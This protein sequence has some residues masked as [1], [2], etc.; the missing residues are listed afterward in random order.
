MLTIVKQNQ[1]QQFPV[2]NFTARTVNLTMII[3]NKYK[4][5]SCFKLR[6]QSYSFEEPIYTL[7]SQKNGA[8]SKVS[9]NKFLVNYSNYTILLWTP[10][11]YICK[12]Q[13]VFQSCPTPR[14]HRFLSSHW[15]SCRFLSLMTSLI[16]SIQFFFG[17]PLA[18][19]CFWHPPFPPVIL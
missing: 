5:V 13:N 3:S 6:R 7:C 19:F 15:P 18:L 2:P 17:L 14:L 12:F 10:C 4:D 16:Q 11:I 8:V 1:G 9:R